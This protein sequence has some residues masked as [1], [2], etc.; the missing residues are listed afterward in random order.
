M[1]ET[2]TAADLVRLPHTGLRVP[3]TSLSVSR[4]KALETSDGVAFTANLRVGNKIVGQIEDLGNGGETMLQPRDWRVYGETEFAAYAARCRT[5]EGTEVN[6]ELLLNELITEHEWT[7]KVRNTD[8]KRRLLLRQMA[9]A[10]STETERADYPPY[11]QGETSSK[12]PGSEAQWTTLRDV[13][14]KRMPPGPHG[15][16]QGWH[17]GRWRDVTPR[18]EGVNTELYG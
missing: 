5:E 12:V 3:D 17:G 9:H 8:A 13:L 4:Y 14:L 1:T 2:K 18:P 15:W 11:P 6:A 16:W 10:M 7:L